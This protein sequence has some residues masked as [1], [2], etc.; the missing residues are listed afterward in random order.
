[1]KKIVWTDVAI[2]DLQNIHAYIARDSETYAQ[3]LI[4]EIFNAVERLEPFPK[5]GRIVPEFKKEDTRELLFGNYRV[6][7]DTAGS[8]IRRLAVI[9]GARLLK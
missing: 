2:D 8:T 9:H 3:A 6:I 5:S 4:L 7:Y 1:M